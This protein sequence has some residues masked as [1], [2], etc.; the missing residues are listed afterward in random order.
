MATTEETLIANKTSRNSAAIGEKAITPKFVRKFI[1]G[2]RLK[3]TATILDF[4]AGKTANH[5]R[6]LVE[7]GYFCLAHEFGDNVD[8]R[9]HYELAM[10]NKYD[11]VYASNV[12]NVQSSMDMFEETI[13]EVKSVMK[14]DS[15]FIANFPLS[16]RKMDMDAAEM[17]ELLDQYFTTAIVASG[18]KNAPIFLMVK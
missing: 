14:L 3:A 4:G 2:Y 12:L 11:V 17:R 15:V 10:L 8:P 18:K 6:A 5:A 16:P 1:D 9:Y 13:E 7:D